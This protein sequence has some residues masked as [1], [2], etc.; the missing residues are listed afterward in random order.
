MA[1]TL[2]VDTERWRGHQKVVADSYPGI[3][4]VTKG[5]GYG[6]G[7]KRLAIEAKALG[8]DT[9]AVG[10]HDELAEV[11]EVFP[12]D[13]M[14]LNPVRSYLP[15]SIERRV[16]HTLSRVTDLQTLADGLGLPGGARHRVVIELFGSVHRFGIG[17]D[18]LSLVRTILA[19][20]GVVCEGFALHLPLPNDEGHQPEVQRWIG[21]LSAAGL[22]PSRMFVSHL[23]AQEQQALSDANP[24]IEFRCR[25]GTQLW[26]AERE[27]YRC[28]AHVLDVHPVR[29]G[30]RFGYRQR[31]LPAEG[32]LVV[33]SGGTANG[34]ALEPPSHVGDL[35]TRAKVLAASGLEAAGFALSPYWIG[36]QRRW[37]A[38]PPHMQVSM[39]F[40]PTSVTPPD[41]GEEIEVNVG[42]TLTHFDRISYD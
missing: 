27:S 29:R 37:F 3:V 6:F 7:S 24:D 25:V 32:N 19:D 16:I 18:D 2:Y 41:L 22:N 28:R 14:V 30:E 20:R 39:L 12:G 36:G 40:L 5:N 26:L 4:P 38:E 17:A 9:L 21:R 1:L 31:R 8:A 34:I 42:M 10:T 23:S 11:A 33:V 15:R 35:R 13:L